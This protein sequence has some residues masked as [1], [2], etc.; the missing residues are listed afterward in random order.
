MIFLILSSWCESNFAPLLLAWVSVDCCQP[1]SQSSV[2]VI[3]SYARIRLS[4]DGILRLPYYTTGK[5]GITLYLFMALVRRIGSSLLSRKE[6]SRFL[7]NRK[8]LEG[9]LE[10]FS[11][12]NV[13]GISQLS[14]RP[15]VLMYGSCVS[16]TAFSNAD[17]D[18][19]VLFLTQ[20]N[21]EESSMA[22]MLN[23]TH[24]KFIEVKREHHQ[25]VLLS[26]LEHI[27]VS[28][29]STVVKCE[30]IYSARVPFIRLFK[31]GSNNTEGSH[32]DVSLSFDGPRNSLLLRLYMEGDP[33]L[34]CGVLCAK[35]WCRSQGILDARRGWISAYALTVMYIFYMQVTKRTV[36]IIDESEVNNILYCM[37][38]QM[39]EGVNECFPFVGDVCS[40]SDVDIQNVLSDLHGFFHFFGGS[41]CFDFDTDVVDIRKN[42]KLVSKESWLE[43][44]NHFDERT[45]WNLLGYETIMIRDPYE[46]HNLGRSVD[47]FRGERIREVFRLAS[48]TKIEDVLNELAKQGRLSSV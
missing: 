47:F 9:A 38:K 18:Y 40:C 26:I 28:F 34:R 16:G 37:S 39:L 21:T 20:G 48:E 36:R 13:L 29:C 14:S 3:L 4:L 43:G 1:S 35:K 10:G 23:Y 31:S 22:N 15:S 25:K 6:Y 17:A 30:Q 46:D 45:R 19:A 41:M 42:D 32:L 24:S 27:R 11:I 7:D 12:E 8:W 44:I 5:R 2:I 33:R